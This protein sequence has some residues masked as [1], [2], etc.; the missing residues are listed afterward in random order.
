MFTATRKISIVVL[1]ISAAALAFLGI[2]SIWE[3]LNKDD[4]FKALTSMG[5][6]AFASFLVIVISLEREGKL[7][8]LM[9][10]EG[11]MSKGRLTVLIIVGLFLL[12]ILF[13]FLLRPGYY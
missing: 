8:L 11:S 7:W 10:H 9:A 6:I 1:G 12:W 2:L 5:I 13:N 3:V 4:V